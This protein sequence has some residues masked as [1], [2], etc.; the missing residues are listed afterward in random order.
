MTVQSS[1]ASVPLSPHTRGCGAVRVIFEQNIEM[2]ETTALSNTDF[3]LHYF[4]RQQDE[5]SLNLFHLTLGAAI[6]L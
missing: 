4:C 2:K 3:A 6:P 5:L 1:T